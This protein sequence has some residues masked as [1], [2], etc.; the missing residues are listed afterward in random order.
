METKVRNE[1][2]LNHMENKG[3]GKSKEETPKRRNLQNLLNRKRDGRSDT[4]GDL[5][6]EMAV[7]IE[8]DEMGPDYETLMGDLNDFHELS[9]ELKDKLVCAEFQRDSYKDQARYYENI[10][11]K[12]DERHKK[13]SKQNMWMKKWIEENLPGNNIKFRC[14]FSYAF[15]DND[16][17]NL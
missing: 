12:D 10:N 1:W 6:N 11:K 17:S 8:K 16:Y 7:L 15:S 5:M 4:T 14:D 3:Y 2:I 13:M 9:D